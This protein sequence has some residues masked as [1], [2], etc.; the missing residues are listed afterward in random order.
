M[1]SLEGGTLQDLMEWRSGPLTEAEAALAMADV[2]RFLAT[3]HSHQICFADTKPSN[4]MF[5]D[6]YKGLG[7]VPPGSGGLGLRAIDMGCSKVVR[8]GTK[9][10][11]RMGT[12]AYFAPEVF[13]RSYDTRA[14]LW[15]AGI[16]AYQMLT[17]RFPYWPSLKSLTTSDVMDSVIYK[18]VPYDPQYWSHLSPEAQDFTASL[19]HRQSGL[20]MSAKDGLKHPWITRHLDQRG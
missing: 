10:T 9:L 17:G 5:A 3:C 18:K 4:F 11:K 8:D 7:S 2:L 16:L 13:L 15:S 14:D 12:P 6:E 1:D 19:L 20:R